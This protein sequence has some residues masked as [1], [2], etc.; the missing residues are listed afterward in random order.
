M[1]RG[2]RGI[3]PPAIPGVALKE[4]R[5]MGHI[6]NSISRAV[7]VGS[8]LVLCFGCLMSLETG[9]RAN[10]LAPGDPVVSFERLRTRMIPGDLCTLSVFVDDAVD[11]LSCMDIFVAFD[12][13]LVECTA[14]LEGAL[15]QQVGYPSFFRWEHVTAD[16][17]DAVD[18]FLG[19]RSFFL[20][21]GELV[22]F[23]F[24]AKKVGIS[25][26]CIAKARLWDIDRVELF[27]VIGECAEI[28]ASAPMVSFEPPRILAA[29]GELCTLQ[30]VV[31]DPVDSLSCMDIA[32]TFD[33]SLVE[34]TNALEGALYQGL[35][36]PTF[37]RWNRVSADTVNAVD[38]VLGYR[39]Y[40][41]AP[42]ELASFV[43]KAKKVGVC[44][45]CF[46]QA[47]LWDIDRLELYPIMGPCAEI[48]I[49]VPTGSDPGIPRESYLCNYPNPFNPSTRL[50]LFLAPPTGGVAASAATVTIYAPDG[51]RIRSLFDGA[52]PAGR[53][54][55]FWDGKNDR[56]N[57]VSA[58]VYF[59]VAETEWD[60]FKRKLILVR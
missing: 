13:S 29:P 23:V 34:C 27:P 18:C 57:A 8:L 33:T 40:F 4:R 11:S 31:E 55:L 26:V 16:T 48:S 45:V 46:S 12:T 24:R 7:R 15:Y 20:A 2:R 36:Y 22:S 50:V 47:R 44:H 42:G 17:V 25:H 53:N 21:P 10:P 35:S 37:F 32:V 14:A 39:T 60:T 1:G 52:M 9:A 41:L 58:G 43:F 19:Y 59:A 49:S 28:V 6:E 30:V 56:G 5:E 51:N 38:C 3:A 54:E